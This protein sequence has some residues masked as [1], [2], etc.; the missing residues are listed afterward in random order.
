MPA[1]TF[2][3]RREAAA[4]LG[5]SLSTFIRREHDGSIPTARIGNRV[6]VPA[7]FL[8]KL[9]LETLNALADEGGR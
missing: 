4:A 2:L 8:E 9:A 6:L 1:T 7:A 5:I 3:S